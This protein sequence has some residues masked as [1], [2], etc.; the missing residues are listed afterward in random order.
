M[1]GVVRNIGVH[2]VV[3]AFMVFV[4]P[5]YV[6][7]ADQETIIKELG[8]YMEL[9]QGSWDNREPPPEGQKSSKRRPRHPRCAQEAPNRRPRV[10]KRRPSLQNRKISV[11]A[12]RCLLASLPERFWNDFFVFRIVLQKTRNSPLKGGG[13]SFCEVL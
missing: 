7:A 5:G 12:S 3:I 10:P 4:F 8:P 6:M 2:Q 9:Y 11:S 1:H 13:H